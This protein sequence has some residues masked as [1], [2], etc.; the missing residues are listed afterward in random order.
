MRGGGYIYWGDVYWVRGGGDT[1]KGGHNHEAG[2]RLRGDYLE[3]GGDIHQ[4]GGGE[5]QYGGTHLGKEDGMCDRRVMDFRD[6]YAKGGIKVKVRVRVR[7]F[8][9]N[10]NESKK[11]SSPT[12]LT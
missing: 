11:K 2:D 1:L 6:Q 10:S 7:C 9:W 3:G 4:R 5:G 12:N 8:K